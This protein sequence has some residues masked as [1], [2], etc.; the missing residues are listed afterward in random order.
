[1]SP[2]RTSTSP[3]MRPVS[4]TG[5]PRTA[6]SPP[7]VRSAGTSVLPLKRIVDGLL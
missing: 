5:P 7:I 6:T 4:S 1:M 2:F 3:S